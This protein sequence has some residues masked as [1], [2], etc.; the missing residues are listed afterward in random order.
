MWADDPYWM[1]LLLDNKHFI[2]KLDFETH[3]KLVKANVNQVSQEL[4]MT[5]YNNDS[6]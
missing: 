3:E 1:P 2:G 4:I 6:H 5:L